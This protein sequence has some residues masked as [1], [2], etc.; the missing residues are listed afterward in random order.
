M[1]TEFRTG[2]WVHGYDEELFTSEGFD[3]RE[4][5]ID[6]ARLEY[7][8]EGFYVGRI[9]ERK[10]SDFVTRYD[11]PRLLDGLREAAAD[12]VG[13]AMEHWLE[14]VSDEATGCS[15]RSSPCARSSM[16]RAPTAVKRRWRHESAGQHAA[17][18]QPARTERGGPPEAI[19]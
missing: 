12:D 16:L 6:D 5:A 13:D 3:T 18:V 15:R 1:T 14:K 9:A 2:Q 4:D 17:A 11:G 8:G 7:E 10:A 19:L